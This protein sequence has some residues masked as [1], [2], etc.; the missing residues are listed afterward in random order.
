MLTS[1]ALNI[2]PNFITNRLFQMVQLGRK[3][4]ESIG[5][6]KKLIETRV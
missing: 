5:K 4:Y 1:H 6:R 2:H 3:N